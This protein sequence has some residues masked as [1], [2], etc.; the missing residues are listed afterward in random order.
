MGVFR[1]FTRLDQG[2]VP[3]THEGQRNEGADYQNEQERQEEYK[4]DL[5][6]T[7]TVWRHHGIDHNHRGV[8]QA[9][10]VLRRYH[11]EDV[12]QRQ[13]TGSSFRSRHLPLVTLA[14]VARDQWQLEHDTTLLSRSVFCRGR[15][16]GRVVSRAPGHR[17]VGGCRLIFGIVVRVGRFRGRRG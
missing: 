14:Q 17:R 7:K 4:H 1:D 2:S 11:I 15:V 5:V 16:A 6:D 12:A 3:E 9:G 10:N 13:R 8:S